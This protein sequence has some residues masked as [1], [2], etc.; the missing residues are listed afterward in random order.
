MNKIT[1]LLIV[2]LFVS[3]LSACSGNDGAIPVTGGRPGLQLTVESPDG[4]S[5]FRQGEK[6]VT[7]NYVVTN[8]GPQPLSGPVIVE[9]APRQVS[10]PQLNTVGNLD[11]KLDFNE[12]ITCTAFYTPSDSER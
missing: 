8:T 5:A 10:C 12:S 9:D 2:I 3:L 4:E 1:H 7:Y 6:A 11:D